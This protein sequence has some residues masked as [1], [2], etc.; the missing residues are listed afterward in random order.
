MSNHIGGIL[1]GVKEKVSRAKDFLNQKVIPSAQ[2]II[3]NR[4]DILR[5]A[6]TGEKT[7]LT[8]GS[9]RREIA[10]E[11][12]GESINYDEVKINESSSTVE[13]NQYLSGNTSPRPYVLGNTINSNSE[14]SDEEFIHEM[15]HIYQYQ[16]GGWSYLPDAASNPNYDYDHSILERVSTDSNLDGQRL[17]QFGLE[18]QAEIVKDY[19]RLTQLTDGGSVTLETGEIVTTENANEYLELYQPYIDEIQDNKPIEGVRKEINETGEEVLREFG[20]GGE[21]IS[22][23]LIDRNYSGVVKESVETAGEM[24]REVV[25]GSLETT[26]EVAEDVVDKLGDKLKFWD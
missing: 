23:E 25:E 2:E 19:F 14:L 1:G 4:E 15:M 9:H 16:T 18:Q 20:Q 7:E 3:E 26:R 22:R 12:F 17:Q 10:S 13:V 6:A 21:E 5:Q 24:G 11:I 8:E